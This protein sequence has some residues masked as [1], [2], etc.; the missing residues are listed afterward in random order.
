LGGL[1]IGGPASGTPAS[2]PLTFGRGA[3]GRAALGLDRDGP[4]Y[5]SG[6]AL[7]KYLPRYDAVFPRI[8]HAVG[9]CSFVFIGFAKSASVTAIFWQRLRVAFAAAGLDADRYC[10]MLEPM[11]RESFVASAGLADVVLDTIGWSGGKSTL[12]CLAQNPAIVTLQ[13]RFMRGRHTAAILRRIGCDATIASSID[14]YVTIAARLGT[15]AA[16]A[17]RVRGMVRERKHRA[18][19]D[20]VSIR[21][22]EAFLQGSIR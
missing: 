20:T 5:W 22:L 16:L 13:G 3:F 1:A 11:S 2:G 8:A 4:V 12:D 9:A 19:R 21:A 7:Y 18:F 17:A 6:Q 14:D 10:V 15:D